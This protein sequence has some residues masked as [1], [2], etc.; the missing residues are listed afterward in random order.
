M[1]ANNSTYGCGDSLDEYLDV[2]DSTGQPTGERRHRRSV[3]A[4]GLPHAAVHI[5]LVNSF[6]A[7]I[8]SNSNDTHTRMCNH[9]RRDEVLMQ[10][11]AM[12]KI[13]FPGRWDISAAG[14]VAAGETAADTAQREVCEELGVAD[15][16]APAWLC[17]AVCTAVLNGGTHREHEFV[18][19][20]GIFVDDARLARLAL[21]LQ[22][23]EVMD[24]R[25]MPVADVRA[26]WQRHDPAFVTLGDPAIFDTL[27]EFIRAHRSSNASSSSS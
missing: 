12:T 26:A 14:H 22:P 11:R 3:H 2:L 19:V 1:E 18:Q 21:R 27:L 25:W 9:D 23:T 4:L 15:L 6:A 20:Y 5:W 7:H 13:A 17:A 10:R 8:T 24:A 16:P